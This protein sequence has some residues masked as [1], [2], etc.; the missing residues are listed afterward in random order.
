MS[1]ASGHDAEVEELVELALSAAREAAALVRGRAGAQVSVA[2][3]KS[4][5]VDVV[6]QTDRDAEALL[7]GRLLAARPDDAVMGEEGDDVAG[8]SGVRWILDPIDGTVNFL[9]GIP[10]YAVCVAAERDGDVV[11]GVVID[12]AKDRT[13]LARPDAEGRLIATRDGAPLRVRP[14]A[15]LGLRL[16]ATGFSYSRV[17]REVQARAVGALLPQV[18]DVRR[19]GSCA[20]DLCGVAEGSLDAYVEEGVNLWDHAAAGLIARAA[21]ARLEL[22]VGAGGG[23][24]LVA[25]A[26]E[27]FE[28]FRALTRACGFWSDATAPSST[29]E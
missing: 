17:T 16:V 12:V 15:D 21:G 27:G 22:G 25:A 1:G 14:P 2:A 18:R 24:L 9:Y 4:S 8:T 29:A 28:E 5:E 7:R 19:L 26:S 23:T 3:T 20:L 6:T 10:Q 13:Y 11:V